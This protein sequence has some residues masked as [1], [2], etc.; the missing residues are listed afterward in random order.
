MKRLVGGF[1]CAAIVAG[2]VACGTEP[3]AAQSAADDLVG[4]AV[5]AGS[6]DKTAVHGLLT[7]HAPRDGVTADQ[8]LGNLLHRHWDDHG[9][10]MGALFSWIGTDAKASDPAVAARAGESAAGLARYLGDHVADLLNLDGP[11]TASVGQV[12]PKAV[13]QISAAL[14]P[15][16]PNMAGVRLPGIAAAGFPAP[17]GSDP[18]GRDAV[19]VFAVVGSDRDAAQQLVDATFAVAGAIAR[20]WVFAELD[21]RAAT[22]GPYEYGVLCGILDRGLTAEADDRTRDEFGDTT[23]PPVDDKRQQPYVAYDALLG[24]LPEIDIATAIQSH[25]GFI[26]HDARYTYLFDDEGQLRD[27]IQLMRSGPLSGQVVQSDLANV[28]CNDS[29]G[30]M[31]VPYLGFYGRYRQ[32]RDAVE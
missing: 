1:L 20:E 2:L 10:A 21:H 29:N 6:A 4:H 9:A 14:T 24:A 13:Q 28:I 16:I 19:N 27:V 32:G 26:F 30:R 31:E 5:A 11:R 18:I 23:P 7:G 25:N 17:D 15:Y 3:S 22:A 12:N 8:V